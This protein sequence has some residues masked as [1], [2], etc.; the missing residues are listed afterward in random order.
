S[1]GQPQLFRSL[2]RVLL[3]CVVL[4]AT[5]R[6]ALA[7]DWSVK[8]SLSE[9]LE[10]NSN[11][12]LIEAPKGVTFNSLSAFFLT[13][14]ARTKTSRF[15]IN[16]DVSYYQYFGPGAADLPLQDFTQNG[17]SFQ[18]EQTGNTAGDKLAVSASWRRQDIA[19]SQFNDIA[20]V[21]ARGESNTYSTSASLS[22]QLTTL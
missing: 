2:F 5:A 11:L 21:T 13:L 17:L 22:R 18:F 3:L 16:G 4:A 1:K 15:S 7:A 6:T 19:A 20:A 12:Y 9:T 10:A 8:S 14:D